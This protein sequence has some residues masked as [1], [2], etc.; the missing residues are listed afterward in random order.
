MTNSIVRVYHESGQNGKHA[1]WSLKDMKKGL[2]WVV[3]ID[4]P[5]A[6]MGREK[7]KDLSYTL[8]K[9]MDGMKVAHARCTKGYT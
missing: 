2:L 1:M 9:E 3:D 8:T 6:S 5:K 4:V 7:M